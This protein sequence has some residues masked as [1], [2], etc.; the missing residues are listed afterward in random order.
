MH[1]NTVYGRIVG[2]GLFCDSCQFHCR[3]LTNSGKMEQG[4][5]IILLVL[6]P[7]FCLRR[8]GPSPQHCRYALPLHRGGREASH[9]KRV[10]YPILSKISAVLFE[11]STWLEQKVR[12]V[13]DRFIIEF[14]H[15]LIV[16]RQTFGH[17]PSQCWVGHIVLHRSYPEKTDPLF[18]WLR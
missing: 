2:R 17:C 8:P 15:I 1:L 7:L 10:R 12:K 18:G 14:Y 5:S 11:L 13:N 3:V 16:Q 4:T 6:R 9:S